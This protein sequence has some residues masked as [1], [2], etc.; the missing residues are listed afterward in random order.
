M[1]SQTLV[2]YL[3]TQACT[4]QNV[5]PSVDHMALAILNRLVEV[6]TIPRFLHSFLSEWGGL[7]LHPG[8]MSGA[9]GVL[10]LTLE[11]PPSL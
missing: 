9:V 8:G 3:H 4:V 5:S 10:H 7:Y 1:L 11:K 6:E 2:H